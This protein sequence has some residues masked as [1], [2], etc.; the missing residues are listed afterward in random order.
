MRKLILVIVFITT[1]MSLTAQVSRGKVL[2]G[3]KMESKILGKE[4]RYTVY[5]PFDYETSERYYPIVYLLHGYTD[6][7][8]G[9]IQFG[10][11]NMLA[12]DAIAE[13]EI[14]PMILVMPDAGVSW[15]INNYDGSINYEDFFI[16]EFMPSIESKYRIRK[17][18]RYRG[19]AGLSMGG[20]GTLVYALRHTELFAACAA[21][22]PAIYPKEVF[23]TIPQQWWEP[24]WGEV[25]GHNLEGK[26]RITD[27][28]LKYNPLEFI[29]KANIEKLRSVRIYIDIGDDDHLYKGSDRLHSLLRD[30]KIPHEYRVRDGRHS[31]TYWR[32]GIIDGL[33]FIGMSFHQF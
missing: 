4:V 18:K 24:A 13:H 1:S 21:F 2:E 20:F 14:P 16:Q 5:L 3:L 27:N 12:D 22:S 29:P 11:V 8:M 28:Y 32:S 31:W 7:D 23:T 30:L 9:W 26:S 17:E 25:Y 33:K 10:E 15:Y 6:N 19:V